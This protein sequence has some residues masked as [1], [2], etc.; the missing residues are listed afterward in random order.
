M[1][2][3]KGLKRVWAVYAS[4]VV[5]VVISHNQLGLQNAFSA[6][7]PI[8]FAYPISSSS[9]NQPLEKLQQ[10]TKKITMEDGFQFR[11]EA[12]SE[13]NARSIVDEIITRDPARIRE[14]LSGQD[15]IG[16]MRGKQQIA[17][18]PMTLPRN[19][20]LKAMREEFEPERSIAAKFGITWNI[21]IQILVWAFTPVL[22][23][24]VA[25]WIWRGF[26][27]L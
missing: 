5:V 4:L 18:F 8:S 6:S 15:Y 26:R 21:V 7:T 2:W 13:I 3:I 20:A 14:M 10:K 9:L 11:I 1:N 19:T 17:S 27:P 25:R 16:Y 22:L 23:F 24:L 12:T